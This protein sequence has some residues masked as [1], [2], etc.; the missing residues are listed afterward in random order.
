M[1]LLPCAYNLLRS[2]TDGIFIESKRFF[3][4][5]ICLDVSFL[6]I[7]KFIQKY[8]LKIVKNEIYRKISIFF[9]KIEFPW[10]LLLNLLLHLFFIFNLHRCTLSDFPFVFFVGFLTIV[11]LLSSNRNITSK[12]VLILP[13]LDPNLIFP[14]HL[15]HYPVYHIGFS[16]CF[17]HGFLAI[18]FL[19]S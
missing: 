3:F 12:M 8:Y 18:F 15:L 11:I 7:T 19:L 5:P 13:S 4:Q 2:I 1:I 9:V 16:F 6:K 17:F 14:F 10:D